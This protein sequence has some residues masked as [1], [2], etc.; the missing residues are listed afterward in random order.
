ML[1]L[2]DLQRAFLGAIARAHGPDARS[3][4]TS[5]ALAAEIRGDDRLDPAGRVAIYARMY[6]ARLIDALGEDYPRVAAVLGTD[7]FGELAH[8][9][10]ATHPSTHP[11]LR[12]FGRG[13]AAFLAQATASGIPE[14]LSDLARLEWARLAAF[15]A[16]EVALLDVESL[17]RLPP[18]GW[19]S[20]RLHLAPAVQVLRVTW[21]VHRIWESD[22]SDEAWRSADTWSRVW[23]QG[24][25]VYQA[26]MD[27]AER[28]AL[29]CVEAG[30]E[31]GD[32]CG[33]LTSVVPPDA[34]AHTA[35]A[36]VL[37]WM[38]DG[39]LRAAPTER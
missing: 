16:P 19:A 6:C 22:R 36:L 26:S 4:G 25:K 31:F 3:E 12:W 21:P 20:L 24:D 8:E 10:V 18:E 27:A 34:A 7:R 29:A 30:D 2:P 32:V 9:Y 35:G 14:F 23:R 1:R 13:F 38:E 17:R 5:S 33:A 37:R 28:T 11:S 39:I 15:D